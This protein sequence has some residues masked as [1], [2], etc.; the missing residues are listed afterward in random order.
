[1]EIQQGKKTLSLTTVIFHIF[2]FNFL[3]FSESI[4]TNKDERRIEEGQQELRM[5]G[6]SAAAAATGAAA[7]PALSLASFAAMAAAGNGS[8]AAAAAAAAAMMDSQDNNNDAAGAAAAAAAN[9]AQSTAT[10]TSAAAAALAKTFLERFNSSFALS[11]PRQVELRKCSSGS[12]SSEGGVW[13]VEEIPPGVRY[14]PF[15]G[16]WTPEPAD[17]RFAWEVSEVGVG[18]RG[19]KPPNLSHNHGGREGG[20]GGS[21]A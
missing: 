3:Y 6:L 2:N 15:M 10:T 13:A 8:A 11:P 12:A 7:S 5:E 21:V 14:G 1:M 4:Q 18:G 17:P 9:A 19:G 20:G 16:K